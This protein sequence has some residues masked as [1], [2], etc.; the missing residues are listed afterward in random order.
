MLLRF[1]PSIVIICFGNC[2]C[3]FSNRKLSN[4]GLKIHSFRCYGIRRKYSPLSSR[5]TG[6][7]AYFL[8]DRESN[9][10]SYVH[11]D[12][13]LFSAVFDGHGGGSV[14]SFLQRF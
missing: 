6:S 7:V 1:F 2:L 4:I 10:D 11:S 13:F 9:E 8:G 14:S 5:V 12:D 3:L